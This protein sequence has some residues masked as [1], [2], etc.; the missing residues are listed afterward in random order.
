MLTAFSY[1]FGQKK[2]LEK[3]LKKENL[4]ENLEEETT[5]SFL[6]RMS[7]GGTKKSFL[8]GTFADDKAPFD[9][10]DY[11][12]L[13]VLDS[14]SKSLDMEE[15]QN[16]LGGNIYHGSGPA[17]AHTPRGGHEGR[18]YLCSDR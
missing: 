15:I 18:A 4:E 7:V 2:R 8:R 5:P 13:F 10:D 11:N 14:H 1:L 16:A 3:N 17:L 6:C 9:V 12:T